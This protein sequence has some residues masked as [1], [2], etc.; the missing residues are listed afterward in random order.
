MGF[1]KNIFTKS[2]AKAIAPQDFG[3]LITDVHSHL[4]PGIDD[5]SKSLD[6]SINLILGLQ[7]LGYKKIVT[8]PHIMFDYY[9]NDK[10][11]ILSGLKRLREAVSLHKIDM[12]IDAAAEY[13]VDDHFEKLIEENDL[14]TFG[15][16]MVLFELSFFEEPRMLDQVIFK[17]QLEGYKP[18]LAHPERYAYWHRSME[19]YE[20]LTDKGVLLQANLGSF[21]G[22]YG[23]EVMKVANYLADNGLIKLL[24]SDTHHMMHIQLFQT[25]KTNPHIHRLVNSKTLLNSKL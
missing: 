2:K 19:N 23:P 17:L 24:G 16:K 22:N 8:T 5:G 14:L 18:V 11:K 6:E 3:A 25:L 15:D 9:R 4:I 12:Q 7:S 21:S 10:E 20:K 1:L 13:Y